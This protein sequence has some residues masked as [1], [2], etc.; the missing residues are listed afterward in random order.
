MTC[1]SLPMLHK[2]LE[3][4]RIARGLSREQLAEL[5]GLQREQI[6]RLESGANFTRDTLLKVLPHL[7]GLKALDLGPTELRPGGTDAAELRDALAGFLES[8]RR[9]LTLLERVS[10]AA[11]QEGPAG[12]TRVWSPREVPPGMEER[13]RRLESELAAVRAADK[14]ES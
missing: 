11:P 2:Q 12:A 9:L 14:H 3:Q 13:L 1:Y 8:G 7:P 6:R 10:V 4:A 5:A